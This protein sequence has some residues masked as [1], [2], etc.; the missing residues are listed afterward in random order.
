MELEERIALCAS[1]G[2][3]MIPPLAAQKPKDRDSLHA[4]LSRTD[5]EGIPDAPVVYDGFEPSGRMHIAQGLMK[6]INV[7][8]MTSSGCEFVFWVAD[9]FALMNDKF[10]GD[11]DK[12][13]DCGRYFIEVWKAC[14]MDLDHVQFKWASDAMLGDAERYWTGVLDVLR[15]TTLNRMVRCSQIMGRGESDQLSIAQILYPAMQCNDIFFLGANICQLGKDQRKVNMLAR[16]YCAATGKKEK[17]MIISHHMLLGLKKDQAKMSKS[18]AMSAIFMDDDAAL[19]REKMMAGYCP[20]EDIPMNPIIDYAKHIVIPKVGEILVDGKTYTAGDALGEA[21]AAGV[22]S[23]EVLKTAVADALNN[24]LDPVR[25]YFNTHPEA[26]AL[27]EKVKTFD[28]NAPAP[29]KTFVE[30][31]EAKVAKLDSITPNGRANLVT[32]ARKAA[33]GT[34]EPI[35]VVINDWIAFLEGPIPQDAPLTEEQ[36]VQAAERELK[37]LEAAKAKGKKPK[38]GSKGPP[39]PLSGQIALYSDRK[40]Y[41]DAVFAKLGM[42]NIKTELQ[43]ALGVADPAY[44]LMAIEVARRMSISDIVS[45]FMG[46]EAV[47]AMAAAEVAKARTEEEV[48][49]YREALTPEEKKHA[50]RMAEI[51]PGIRRSGEFVGWILRIVDILIRDTAVSCYGPDKQAV[52]TAAAKLA[53]TLGCRP[54]VTTEGLNILPAFTNTAGPTPR[55]AKRDETGSIYIDEKVGG[56]SIKGRVMKMFCPLGEPD[57][58]AIM[59]LV[60]QIILP[61][62][63]EISVQVFVADEAEGAE[64]TFRT[65]TSVEELTEACRGESAPIG[66]GQLKRAVLQALEGLVATVEGDAEWAELVKV[67]DVNFRTKK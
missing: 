43:S 61:L 9:W 7:N 67:F 36:R 19:V 58:F 15:N 20:K 27:S 24:I 40:S 11:L 34:T 37:A 6:A 31:T 22:M 52:V 63:G 29:E 41:Y 25:E 55:M 57:E 54:P 28:R 47:E 13:K 42:G 60:G 49:A 16:E 10:G 26:K 59:P 35:S 51:N 17:P 32:L 46:P 50:D 66:P 48:A 1:V 14:G 38:K 45:Q 65:F 44:W 18:D 3:E 23:E 30:G 12:I 53:P 33:L 5:A 2:E 62:C 4:L 64:P 21:Y 39:P 8:K 56:R